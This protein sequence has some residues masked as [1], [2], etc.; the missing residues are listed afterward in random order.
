MPCERQ[1]YASQ[2]RCPEDK[3]LISFIYTH[4]LDLPHQMQKLEVQCRANG[5]NR[6]KVQ[7]NQKKT[8]VNFYY[9]IY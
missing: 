3:T 4:L 6:Q 5:S 8:V 2:S 1:S 9:S 7:K